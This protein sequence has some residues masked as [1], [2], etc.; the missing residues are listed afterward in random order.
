MYFQNF[1]LQFI[2]I[3]C[4]IYFVYL[5]QKIRTVTYDTISILVKNLLI[6]IVLLR[7]QNISN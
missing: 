6:L 3:H 4:Q 1:I 5:I 2:K 7:V